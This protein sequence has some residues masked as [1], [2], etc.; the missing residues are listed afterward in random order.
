MAERGGVVGVPLPDSKVHKAK[1]TNLQK[2][3]AVRKRGEFCVRDETYDRRSAKPGAAKPSMLRITINTVHEDP[4]NPGQMVPSNPA[5]YVYLR[6]VDWANKESVAKLNQWRCQ[7]FRRT[8]GPLRT[9]RPKWTILEHDKLIAIIENHLSGVGID[10]R[11]SR[12]QWDIVADDFNRYFS[13][14][15]FPKAEPLAHVQGMQRKDKSGRSSLF[16][17]SAS[18]FVA[19]STSAIVHHLNNFTSSAARELVGE[20]K[21]LDEDDRLRGYVDGDADKDEFMSIRRRKTKATAVGPCS[22]R[23]KSIAAG[24]RAKSNALA[25]SGDIPFQLSDMAVSVAQNARARQPRMIETQN[26]TFATALQSIPDLYAPAPDLLHLPSIINPPQH[27]FRHAP[28]SRACG[29]DPTSPSTDN[30]LT[31]EELESQEQEH[32]FT[33][34][35]REQREQKGESFPPL[36]S[37]GDPRPLSPFRDLAEGDILS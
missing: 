10:G 13:G 17:K 3:R 18:P 28:R 27:F 4:H 11:Y 35:C 14:C 36:D 6:K 20:A 15:V 22:K 32:V 1:L 33:K 19:R 5:T 8:L 30:D 12:I 21:A 34:M 37:A 31:E 24:K 26:P 7:V 29:E 2:N 9:S 16:M 23:A 25:S